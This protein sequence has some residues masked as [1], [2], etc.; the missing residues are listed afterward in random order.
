MFEGAGE[1]LLS[2]C[3]SLI[4][5][6]ICRYSEVYWV[7]VGSPLYSKF[8]VPDDDVAYA[9]AAAAPSVGAFRSCQPFTNASGDFWLRRVNI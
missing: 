9:A 2:A 3:R 7:E 1:P 5:F 4:S 6:G 8:D